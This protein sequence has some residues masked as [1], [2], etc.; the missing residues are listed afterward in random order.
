MFW[1]VY[2]I[3]TTTNITTQIWSLVYPSHAMVFVYI[4]AIYVL[5]GCWWE[6]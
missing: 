6:N 5:K 3:I 1:I 4:F 2:I